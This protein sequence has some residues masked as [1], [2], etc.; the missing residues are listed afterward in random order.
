MVQKSDRLL[1]DTIEGNE[2]AVACAIQEVHDSEYAPNFYNNEQSLWYVIKMAYLSCVDQYAK[3]EELPSGHGLADVVF[4][5]NRRSSLP[6]MIIE[7]KWNKS[8]EGAIRQIL[9]KNYPKILEQ[10]GG[11]ILLAGINYDEKTK[12]HS[13]KIVCH[14]KG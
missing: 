11:K 2:N 1:Q 3:V 4:L 10:F 5:P 7:L 8:E 9:D 6:A 14:Q 12:S 13:C